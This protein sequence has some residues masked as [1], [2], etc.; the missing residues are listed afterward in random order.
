LTAPGDARAFA[1]GMIALLQ[2]PAR[3]AE[4]GRR[5]ERRIWEH[6][7]WNQQAPKLEQAYHLLTA[8]A[9]GRS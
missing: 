6:Y 3:A 1:E 7:D 4:L 8:G 9:S 2:D 5:A